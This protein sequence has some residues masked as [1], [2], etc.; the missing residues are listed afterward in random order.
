MAHIVYMIGTSGSGKT[1]IANALKEE[2]DKRGVK[3]LQLIDGDVIGQQFGGLFGYTY[4]ERMKNN[5]AVRVVIQY[6]LDNNISVILTQVAPYEEVRRKMREHFGERYVEIYVKCSYEECVRR[7]P[8]GYYKKHKEGKMENLNGADDTFE[9]PLNSDLI[10][11]T[12][13]ESV[14]DAVDKLVK[15][16]EEK[17]LIIN[18][19]GRQ[20]I[21]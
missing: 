10:I 18:T 7:D 6:L 14:F 15:F 19:D 5:Q 13:E 12:E 16:F 1:T 8:K 2:L 20:N 11:D 3:Q 17:N 4:E 21:S 9:V